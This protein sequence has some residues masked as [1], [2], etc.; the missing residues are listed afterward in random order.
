MYIAISE[1][2]LLR[3]VNKLNCQHSNCNADYDIQMVFAS[4]IVF[5]NNDT[6]TNLLNPICEYLL[7][8]SNLNITVQFWLKYIVDV[9]ETPQSFPPRCVATVAIMGIIK[10]VRYIKPLRLVWIK[11]TL[12]SN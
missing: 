4:V 12:S 5:W 9:F 1:E 11:A 10:Q 6:A 2:Y 3:Q 8:N 7:Q